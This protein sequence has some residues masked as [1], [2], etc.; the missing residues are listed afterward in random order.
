MTTIFDEETEEVSEARFDEE[1]AA[2]GGVPGEAEETGPAAAPAS[3][4]VPLE[5][6]VTPHLCGLLLSLPGAIQARRTGH[7]FWLISDEE[8][9]LL[10]EASQPLAVYLVRKY[11]GEQIGMF[12]S[13]VV[14]MTAVYAPRWMQE[15]QV[16]KK[17]RGEGG[18][19]YPPPHPRS[20]PAGSA[21]SSASVDAVSPSNSENFSVPFR[22]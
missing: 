6:L 9:R 5:S 21:P 13:T 11:L 14:A 20:S 18:P 1:T 12:A 22:E 7:D 8:A 10:G 4:E 15:Q 2:I 19:V 3:E 17:N 16:Q